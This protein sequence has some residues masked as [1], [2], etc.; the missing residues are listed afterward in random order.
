MSHVDALAIAFLRDIKEQVS[1]HA[2][3]KIFL[4]LPNQLLLV[5]CRIITTTMQ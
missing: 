2:L 5:F 4:A 1:M 3:S